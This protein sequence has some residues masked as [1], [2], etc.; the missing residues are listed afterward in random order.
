MDL[1][2][3]NGS[4]EIIDILSKLSNAISNEPICEVD[5]AQAE[6]AC[7]VSSESTV[8]PLMPQDN[9][10]VPIVFL[11]DNFDCIIKSVTG[12]GSVNTTHLMVFQEMKEKAIINQYDTNIA[13]TKG[14][15]FAANHVKESTN[16]IKIDPRASP[17]NFPTTGK[18]FQDSLRTAVIAKDIWN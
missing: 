15:K 10:G 8:L 2:G 7:K 16:G 3:L 18:Y 4:R 9:G 6:K 5:T 13:R 1:H 11:L 17:P 14:R 12:G